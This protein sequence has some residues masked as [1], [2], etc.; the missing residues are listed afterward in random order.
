MARKLKVSDEE[1][2]EIIKANP[3]MTNKAIVAKIG[4]QCGGQ[5]NARV[6]DL[7]AMV[8]TGP[9]EDIQ[10]YDTLTK[11]GR[12]YRVV[13]VGQDGFKIKPTD[14]YRGSQYAEPITISKE[15]FLSG[16]SGYVK[17]NLP[18]V[19]SYIDPTLKEGKGDCAE[20]RSE[21]IT[22]KPTLPTMKEVSKAMEERMEKPVDAKMSKID[23]TGSLGSNWGKVSTRTAKTPTSCGNTSNKTSGDRAYLTKINQLL[24]IVMPD[25]TGNM[26]EDAIDLAVAMLIAGIR[27][28]GQ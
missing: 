6:R 10:L 14:D 5:I 15:L 28:E 25:C 12:W 24:D 7:K 22:E 1:I 11:A 26:V 27:E 21:I 19:K 9:Q 2:I 8:A 23:D 4:M 16:K 13:E 17:K 20:S 18:P 3:G